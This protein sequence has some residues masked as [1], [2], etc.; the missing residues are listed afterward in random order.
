MSTDAVE[1]SALNVGAD[2]AVRSGQVFVPCVVYS[3]DPL[4]T[5]II[6]SVAGGKAE[7]VI[8]F[9]GGRHHPNGRHRSVSLKNLHPSG[10]TAAGAARK[11]GWRLH[12]DAPDDPNLW[13]CGSCWTYFDR[14]GLA[15]ASYGPA[16]STC[17]ACKADIEAMFGPSA[18]DQED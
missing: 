18:I 10:T 1:Q 8:P 13:L 17:H 12:T 15:V 9:G 14:D 5:F 3:W 16:S 4:A 6:E 7:V 11:T 2:F